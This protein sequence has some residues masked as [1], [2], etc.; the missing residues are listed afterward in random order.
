MAMLSIIVPCYNEEAVVDRFY[1]VMQD[2]LQKLPMQKEYIFVDDGSKDKTLELLQSLN[3][4]D[5]SAHYVSFS[6][7]F[8]RSC[9]LCRAS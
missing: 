6:R 8:G 3:K 1:E 9:Y 2:T 7:N 5:P 4:R